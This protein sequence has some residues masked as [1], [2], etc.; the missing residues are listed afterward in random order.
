MIAAMAISE[1]FSARSGTAPC[2]ELGC[3]SSF[4]VRC[5]YV[6]RRGKECATSWCPSHQYIVDGRVH[7]RRH[8]GIMVAILDLPDYERE[9]P[10]L[11]NR[12]PALVEFMARRLHAG[13]VQLLQ[14]VGAEHPGASIAADGLHATVSGSGAHRSRGWEH[15]WR[16]Y[17][18]T[19]PLA[20]LA[21]RVDE[22]ADSVVQVR[23]DGSVVK[24][25]IPP[26]IT[27]RA[28]ASPEA[29]VARRDAF[30]TE[31]LTA[32]WQS[33]QLWSRGYT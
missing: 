13:M 29:D 4:G 9:L 15:K 19:G 10:D 6:D 18:N 26:W 1:P 27:E 24:S 12:A 3:T 32:M 17:D 21:I 28:A 23:V 22:E 14:A 11:A 30:D 31:L 25:A 8:A 33:P 20:T 2:D 16:L 5:E 7:C